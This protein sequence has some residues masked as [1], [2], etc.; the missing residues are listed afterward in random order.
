MTWSPRNRNNDEDEEEEEDDEEEEEDE[1]EQ[2]TD[3]VS[4][5][6]ARGESEKKS[7]RIWSLAE[8]AEKNEKKDFSHSSSASPQSTSRRT[9]GSSLFSSLLSPK[10]EMKH[11]S[12]QLI[13]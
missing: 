12:R 7:T 1:E 5:L 10:C 13:L 9:L 6:E 8:M 2:F 11:C 4:S 3:S